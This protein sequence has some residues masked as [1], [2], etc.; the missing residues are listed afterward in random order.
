M[1]LVSSAAS[2]L[3]V[4]PIDQAPPKKK[5]SFLRFG[6]W[7]KSSSQDIQSNV[8]SP[9]AR[10]GVDQGDPGVSW[11]SNFSVC[12]HLY[13][14]L[15]EFSRLFKHNVHVDD[16]FVLQQ[17]Y[18]PGSLTPC[19]RLSG[20]PPSWAKSL[21]DKGLTEEEIS[22]INAR[23]L[24]NSRLQLHTSRPNSPA[25]HYSPLIGQPQALPIDRPTTPSS[26]EFN[27]SPLLTPSS[28]S[29]VRKFSGAS[30]RSQSPYLASNVP[31]PH[32]LVTS[33]SLTS[34]HLSRTNST[35]ASYKLW[36][37]TPRSIHNPSSSIAKIYSES[38]LSCQG[39]NPDNAFLVPATPPRRMQV[40]NPS[41][42]PPAYTPSRNANNTNVYEDIKSRNLPSKAS[43]AGTA[44]TVVSLL[45]QSVPPSFH[46]SHASVESM[47]SSQGSRSTD[48]RSTPQLQKFPNENLSRPPRLSL[49]ASDD[50]DDWG[51]LVLSASSLLGGTTTQSSTQTEIASPSTQ[52]IPLIIVPAESTV[53]MDSVQ[54]LPSG[55][56]GAPSASRPSH[57]TAISFSLPELKDEFGNLVEKDDFQEA[58]L[59][60]ALAGSFTS[61]ISE[62][63]TLR[64]G[65]DG[66]S[67]LLP[68]TRYARK[69][70]DDEN[71]EELSAKRSNRDSSQS[72]ISTLSAS[73]M[74]GYTQ[75][76]PQI[77]RNASVI[78][79]TGAYVTKLPALA[80]PVSADRQQQQW[81][82]SSRKPIDQMQVLSEGTTSPENP[83][84]SPMGV[85]FS[86]DKGSGFSSGSRR[87]SGAPPSPI[88]SQFS[89]DESAGSA[90]TNST[91]SSAQSQD[92]PT[93]TT[94]P[95][96]G[97]G[98]GSAVLDFDSFYTQTPSPSRSSFA[99][100]NCSRKPS[101]SPRDTFGNVPKE[102][103]IVKII[104]QDENVDGDLGKDDDTQD[105]ILTREEDKE[106]GAWDILSGDDAASTPYVA[107]PLIVVSGESTPPNVSTDSILLSA[108]GPSDRPSKALI[109]RYPG[110][111]SGVVNPLE[112]FIDA[113]VD[114]RDHYVELQEIAEGE[115]GS[116]F[117]A[118]V[119]PDNAAKL[120]LHPFVK[121]RDTAEIEKGAPALVAIKIIA[122]TP[123][124]S[125]TEVPEAQ[126]LIDLERELNLMKGLWHENILG[127]DALY[128]DLTEDTLWV[129]MELMERSL[130]DIVGLVASGLV[131]HD[132]MIARFALDVSFSFL[133]WVCDV[134]MTNFLSQ[135][136]LAL[137]Y[138]QDNRIAHR[139]VRSDN[140]LLNS[141]GILKLSAFTSLFVLYKH[142]LTTWQ[143]IFLMQ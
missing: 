56:G 54:S 72:S 60:A 66:P 138:L 65:P 42:P 103:T 120:R 43:P 34:L 64:P 12:I 89:S 102:S 134:M 61:S 129:R 124:C 95:G 127:L 109:E 58:P 84:L 130:A 119:D 99:V 27:A 104:S 80:S 107:R 75:S 110:W 2:Q 118:R 44:S 122:I 4:I 68:E 100:A 48:S 53:H 18:R 59:S 62:K 25:S 69:R 6:I 112:S 11:P 76:T 3:S 136:L 105:H 125:I 143:P 83:P 30:L 77:I 117:A 115:S 17:L 97:G 141:H 50:N 36:S 35:S 70:G 23:R 113:T 87:H 15:F 1:S 67:L 9:P 140:L 22:F 128:V 126:K 29:L 106:Q 96:S 137:Q 40:S 52:P 46:Q 79:R 57:S 85:V 10:Q 39:S 41:S 135:V 13:C 73:T 33:T 93:P 78:R 26:N 98:L 7:P 51:K 45:S 38:H 133:A 5:K 31:V 47:N 108:S 86:V 16:E 32:A 123:P 21:A 142:K 101:P 20:L 14:F 121:S 111:L 88:N 132:R 139:D 8:L 28:A 71:E 63:D 114:P 81:Q 116:I 92:Q 91:L 19:R 55:S 94:D 82:H 37:N 90:S 24:A 74:T 131:L 49:H